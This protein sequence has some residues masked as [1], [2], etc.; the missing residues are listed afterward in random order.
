MSNLSKAD[1][2]RHFSRLNRLFWIGILG[3]VLGPILM[4]VISA[5]AYKAAGSNVS[6]PIALCSPFAAVASI[7]LALLVRTS[8]RIARRSLAIATFAESSGYEYS[9]KPPAE[10]SQTI[11]ELS[12][13]EN[14]TSLE[15]T[16]LICTEQDG[17]DIE[18][19]D[20]R[21]EHFYGA[22]TAWNEQTIVLFP[23]AVHDDFQL[24]IM[25]KGRADKIL[26]KV[27]NY[28]A[29]QRFN[30]LPLAANFHIECSGSD[31]LP[32]LFE[33]LSTVTPLFQK[34]AQLCLTV[35]NGHII[36]FREMHLLQASEIRPMLATAWTALQAFSRLG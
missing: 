1:V 19:A 25:P 35:E 34:N 11:Q 18:I 28:G 29:D 30:K 4:I 36:L 5:V 14:P 6:A 16:N 21:S 3:I 13:W 15:V 8:R 31:D 2:Q 26:G 23:D 10:K 20:V 27:V 7:A 12:L 24:R 9:W 22:V 32:T 33:V 17:V